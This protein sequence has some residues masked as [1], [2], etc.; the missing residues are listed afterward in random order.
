MKDKDQGIKTEI[1]ITITITMDDMTIEEMIVVKEDK[2]VI[3]SKKE[4]KGMIDKVVIGN[5]IDKEGMI[6]K[7]VIGSK[8]DKGGMI[9]KEKIRGKGEKMIE[10]IK[11]I[12]GIIGDKITEDKVEYS[13]GEMIGEIKRNSTGVLTR[14]SHNTNQNKTKEQYSRTK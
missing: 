12:G 13:R 1:A 2:I 9:E 8:K 10:K 7:V 6:D 4:K 11:Y 3:G 14:N 5:K